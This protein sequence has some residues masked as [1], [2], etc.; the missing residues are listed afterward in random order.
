M[1]GWLLGLMCFLFGLTSA[2][3][4]GVFLAEVARLAGGEIARVTGGVLVIAYA[5]L[6]LGPLAF[7]MIAAALTLGAGFAA[8]GLGTLAGSAA[9]GAGRRARAPL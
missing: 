4:N 8:M 7:S 6:I 2:G 9:L 1:S 3:W 5:G